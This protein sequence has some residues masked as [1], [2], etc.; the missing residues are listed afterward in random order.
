MQDSQAREVLINEVEEAFTKGPGEH[1]TMTQAVA[2]Q[3]EQVRESTLSTWAFDKA[4]EHGVDPRLLQRAEAENRL[5]KAKAT[6]PASDDPVLEEQFGVLLTFLNTYS[7]ELN[8]EDERDSSD[9]TSKDLLM[10]MKL[11]LESFHPLLSILK[12]ANPALHKTL[13][14][15]PLVSGQSSQ[16][17]SSRL[18][19]KKRREMSAGGGGGGKGRRKSRGNSLTDNSPTDSQQT[20]EFRGMMAAMV[21]K[22]VAEGTVS[23]H[24]VIVAQLLS[25]QK[26]EQHKNKLS[27]PVA[28]VIAAL[29]ESHR[30]E[31]SAA[32][33]AIP[34]LF[35]QF[36]LS[37]HDKAARKPGTYSDLSRKTE[38]YASADA[39]DEVRREQD[40]QDEQDEQE[41]EQEQEQEEQGA[42]MDMDEVLDASIAGSDMTA[43]R[44]MSDGGM[45]STTSPSMITSLIAASRGTESVFSHF[46]TSYTE[47]VDEY[48]VD[49]GED[50]N[51]SLVD[52]FA[53]G[54]EPYPASGGSVFGEGVRS[55]TPIHESLPEVPMLATYGP[56]C[57]S[58]MWHDLMQGVV[59]RDSSAQ[60]SI[61]AIPVSYVIIALL[62]VISASA[63][64][65]LHTQS[66]PLRRNGGSADESVRSVLPLTKVLAIQP[67][68]VTF[69]LIDFILESL[70][71]ELDGAAR[72]QSVADEEELVHAHVY[73]LVW[74]IGAVL[75][76]LRAN[77]AAA[78]SAGMPPSSLGLGIVSIK[79][80]DSL[81]SDTYAGSLFG[82]G[83]GLQNLPFVTR[84]LRKVA[85]CVS[86]E[87]ASIL[88]SH[89]GLVARALKSMPENPHAAEYMHFLRI[90]GIDTFISGISIFLPQQQDRTKLL[91]L[92]LR[93][94]PTAADCNLLYCKSS[95]PYLTP[96]DINKHELSG[97]AVHKSNYYKLVLLQ[98]VCIAVTK[99][100]AAWSPGTTLMANSLRS[101]DKTE[102]NI[103]GSMLAE[104]DADSALLQSPARSP[105]SKSFAPESPGR[106]DAKVSLE[107]MLLQRL[108]TVEIMRDLE[109]CD[110]PSAG[111]FWGELA[112]LRSIQQKH[113]Q[114]F[115]SSMRDAD[116]KVVDWEFDARRCSPNI[117]ITQEAQKITHRSEKL[118]SSVAGMQAAPP[119]SGMYEWAIKV[120]SCERGHAFVGLVTAAA[121]LD[122]YVGCDA[123]GWGLI[124]TKG[125]WHNKV[126]IVSDYGSGFG[127]NST[128]HM[129]YDS[130]AGTLS[131]SVL[132]A[133]FG[134]AFS[135]LPK[136]PL[137]PAISLFQQ[138]DAILIHSVVRA[139]SSPD[140]RSLQ[141]AFIL[142]VQMLCEHTNA[143]IKIAESASCT[144]EQRMLIASHPFIGVLVP[145][146]A[147]GIS[148]CAMNKV[149][150]IYPTLQLLPYLT[151]MTRKL[152][153]LHEQTGLASTNTAAKASASQGAFSAYEA[154]S[155][156]QGSWE[157]HSAPSGALA[158]EYNIEFRYARGAEQGGSEEFPTTAS[159]FTG[160][161]Q[162]PTSPVTIDGAQFGA[163]VAFTE[164]WT[165]GSNFVAEGEV[166]MCGSFFAGKLLEQGKNADK[167]VPITGMRRALKADDGEVSLLLLTSRILYKTTMIC[168][169]AC[170]N[171]ST[172]LVYGLR[173]FKV[174]EYSSITL[175][176]VAPDGALSMD[177]SDPAAEEGDARPAEDPLKLITDANNKWLH[178]DLLSAGLALDRRLLDMIQSE[179]RYHASDSYSE[180]AADDVQDQAH[181]MSARSLSETF[182][183]KTAAFNG[184]LSWWLSQ[185]FPSLS[186]SASS[187]SPPAS[188]TSR[189]GDGGEALSAS[190]P[191]TGNA[192]KAGA[193]FRVDEYATHHTGQSM[194]KKMGGETMQAARRTVLAA[195]AKHSGCVCVCLAE[196]ESLR[197]GLKLDSDRPSAP[198]M[199]LWRAAKK[200]VEQTIKR[201]QDSG[202]SYATVCES[203]VSMAS[204]LLEVQA[205]SSC[206]DVA[207]SL[208]ILV[209]SSSAEKWQSESAIAVQ[210]DYCRLL[211]EAVDF[212]LSPIRDAMWLK[213]QMSNNVLTALTRAAGFRSIHLLFGPQQP[214]LHMLGKFPPISS[215]LL[216]PSVLM[217]LSN[218]MSSIAKCDEA[219]QSRRSVCG[220][221]SDG[222][223]GVDSRAMQEVK[224]SFEKL[225]ESVAQLLSRCT[226]ANNRDGQCIALCTWMYLRVK[227]EDHTFLN[228]I[229]IFRVLQTVLDCARSSA[230][231]IAAE[232]AEEST[233]DSF[234]IQH[235]KSTN[236]R[237][238]Q[239][240]LQVVHSLASQVAYSKEQVG[241]PASR[242]LAPSRSLQRIQSGP[243]TLS[244]SLFDML[245]NELFNGIKSLLLQSRGDAAGDSKMVQEEGDS[246]RGVDPMLL[247]LSPAAK[248]KPASSDDAKDAEKYMFQILRL[249]YIV[250][251][252]KNCLSSLSS[253]K[254]LTLLVAGIGYGAFGVQRRIM[255]LLRRILV[256]M[257]PE[258]ISAFIPS[259][260]SNKEEILFSEAP[261]DDDDVCALNAEQDSAYSSNAIKRIDYDAFAAPYAARLIS[262][263]LEGVSV[264]MPP[265]RST[266][267]RSDSFLFKYLQVTKNTRGFSVE[268]LN[269]LRELQGVPQWRKVVMDVVHSNLS[270]RCNEDGGDDWELISQKL[271][272]A[273]C[274]GVLGGYFDC[275]HLGGMVYVRPFSLI[276]PNST[277]ATRLASTAHSS[278]MLVSQTATHVEIVEMERGTR[279]QKNAAPGTHDEEKIHDKVIQQTACLTSPL[280]VRALKISIS[281]VTPACDVQFFPELVPGHAF[282]DVVEML[283]N[284][285]VP[286]LKGAARSESLLSSCALQADLT[287]PENAEED[288]METEGE[289]TRGTDDSVSPKAAG[290][291]AATGTS[292]VEALNVFA[293]ASAFRAAS[294]LLRSA[295]LSGI[296]VT[297]HAVL[298][299]EILQLAVKDTKC[300]GLSVL[301]FVEMRW[302]ALWDA[303][304]NTLI[305]A[306]SREDA[307]L[308]TTTT[309][310]EAVDVS[311]RS[312]RRGAGAR[313]LVANMESSITRSI[314]LEAATAVGMFSQ[315]GAGPRPSAADR[316]A[317]ASAIAQMV[318]MGLP[319]EWCEVA[320]RRCRNNVEMAINMCFENGDSM[321]QLVAE[322]ALLQSAA[323]T[324]AAA[325][326]AGGS[327][328]GRSRERPSG[329]DARSAGGGRGQLSISASSLALAQQLQEMGFPQS[330]CLRA[331]G[332]TNN[333]V[334]GALSYIL[335]HG[336]ELSINDGR[337]SPLPDGASASPRDSTE[338]YDPLVALA[339]TYECK[340]DL[341]VAGKSGFPSVGCKNFGVSAGKWYYEVT[342][343]TSGCVQIGWADSAYECSADSG[344]GVGDDIHS[345]AYDGWRMYLWHEL[346]IEWGARWSTGDVLGCAVDMDAR[347]MR[348]SLNGFYEEVGMGVGF[349]QFEYSGTLFPCVSFN[350]NE[351]FQFNFGSTPFRHAPPDEHRGYV[352]HINN[353]LDGVRLIR[354]E[355]SGVRY[356]DA[357]NSNKKSTLLNEVFDDSFERKGHEYTWNTRYIAPDEARNQTPRPPAATLPSKIPTG[358][359]EAILTQFAD[360]SKD[361]CVLYS[362][363]AV[364][365]V[366]ESLLGSNANTRGAQQL[367]QFLMTKESLAAM[368]VD[369][370]NMEAKEPAQ[371][372]PIKQLLHL[373]KLCCVNSNRTKL[374][375]TTMA[376]LAP[377]AS[378]PKNLG[379]LLCIGGSPMLGSLT[380]AMGAMLVRSWSGLGSSRLIVKSVLD[381]V[382][383]ETLMSTSRDYALA[384][385]PDSFAPIV[386]NEDVSDSA[387]IGTP[388]LALAVWM[389]SL[390]LQQF[391]S[392]VS[393][394]E[395]GKSS[396]GQDLH[397][398]EIVRYVELLVQSW[399]FV[400][401][402]SNVSV[403]LCAVN[404]LSILLQSVSASMGS[405]AILPLG[406]ARALAS[407]V[408]YERLRKCTMSRLDHERGSYPIFSEYLQALI[409]L[410]SVTCN[411]LAAS[412]DPLASTGDIA[413]FRSQTFDAGEKAT[414]ELSRDSG[415]AGFDWEATSG[416]VMSENNWITMTGSLKQLAT[417]YPLPQARPV[418]DRQEF[419]PELLPGCVVTRKVIMG[420]VQSSPSMSAQTSPVAEGVMD[421]PEPASAPEP[422][423]HVF[424]N[425]GASPTD[426]FRNALREIMQEQTSGRAPSDLFSTP[427]AAARPGA[428]SA[429]SEAGSGAAS[430]EA[431]R[432][433][434]IESEQ[435]GTV[436]GIAA[437]E[438]DVP[439]SAR[440]VKWDNVEETELVRWN[441]SDYK[442]DVTHVTLA[443]PGK[444]S[445]RYGYPPA[446]HASTTASGF[447]A[448]M[449]FG[450]ILRTRK[451][452]RQDDDEDDVVERLVGIIEWPDFGAEVL[453]KGCVWSDGSWT[454]EEKELLRGPKHT[455][456][457]C[458]F[459]TTSWQRGTSYSLSCPNSSGDPTD[460][461][462]LSLVG[463]CSYTVHSKEHEIEV[464]GD[465]R[466]Q[467]T[468]L[469]TFDDKV[470]APSLQLSLDKLSVSR[471]P[472]SG[473]GSC[474]CVFGTVGFSSGVHFWEFK[475]EGADA[476]S[477]YLG[478]GEK[479]STPGLPDTANLRRKVGSGILSNRTA[480]R[481]PTRDAAEKAFVYG[482]NFHTGDLVGVL[483]DMSRGRLSFFLDGLKFGEHNISDLGDAFQDLSPADRV[484]PKTLFPV[485]GLHSNQD[486]VT[487]TQRW[488]SC[489]GTRAVDELDCIDKAWS[490]LNSW[491]LERKNS[492]VPASTHMWIYR[493]GWRNWAQWKEN[494]YCRIRTRCK[495]T[496]VVI[497]RTVRA[498]AEAS[499]RLGLPIAMFRGDR[500]LF[501]R[502]SGR[503]LEQKEEAVV[504]GAFQGR[505]WYRLDTQQTDIASELL[506]SAELAWCL[507]PQDVEDIRFER[508]LPS[509]PSSPTAR[510]PEDPHSV[511]NISSAVR[512]IPLARIPAYHG[513]VL[514]I[515]C[516]Y[517]S[518][519]RD[520]VEIDTADEINNVPFGTTIRAIERRKNSSNITR[521]KVMYEG[522]CGWISERMRGETEDMMVQ[523]LHL[524]PAEEALSQAAFL[525]LA[526]EMDYAGRVVWEDV[527]SLD[528]AMASWEDKVAATGCSVDAP[529][530]ADMSF[531]YY[532]RLATTIDGQRQWS[533]EADMQLSEVISRCATRDGVIPSNLSPASILRALQQIDN[534]SS[535][536]LGLDPERA[537]ARAALM[538]VANQLIG[539]AL[540]ALS[541]SLPEEK[542]GALGLGSDDSIDV[543]PRDLTAALPVSQRDAS[544]MH[545]ES[546]SSSPVS[547]PHRSKKLPR[548]KMQLH[549]DGT[550]VE[551]QHVWAPACGARRL[552]SLRRLFFTHTKLILWDSILDA[553]ETPTNLQHDEY[554]DPREIKTVKLNRV[555]ATQ[556]RLA[557][558]VNPTDRLRQSVFGQLHKEARSWPNSAFRRS[559]IGKGHGGQKRSFKVQFLGEGVNDYGGPYRALFDQIVDELQCDQLLV[560]HK[561]SERCLLP[562]LV[563][564][565]NR[566]S[567]VGANQDKFVLTSAPSS[568][569][570]QELCQFFG[571]LV[572]TAVRH[573][574][575]LAIDFSALLWRTLVKSPV[576]LAHLETVDSLTVK[577]IH[578]VVEAGL[579]AERAAQE[580]GTDISSSAFKKG[581][582][583]GWADLNFTTYLP[584]GGKVEL[585]PGG[586]DQ[587]VTLGNWRAYVSLLEKARLS[588]SQVMFKTF[589]DGL[590]AVLPVKLLPLFTSTELEELVSG[591]SKVDIAL[592]RQCTE[593]DDVD[594]ES[595]LVK[596]FWSV[597]E[598]FNNDERTSFLRFV[599][600]R[601]RLPTS[602][603]DFPMNFKLQGPQ[604]AAKESKD[605]D[606]YLPHA[607]TCFFSLSLPAYSSL[608]VMREKLLYAINNSPNMDA[609][610]RLHSAEG[611]DT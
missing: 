199:E 10:S 369:M 450:I 572:G 559:Y 404:M 480:Y 364:L 68:L 350:R 308:D 91:R 411:C 418:L 462:A 597:L 425:P 370:E 607:Q 86:C 592:L 28:N 312:N 22:G 526:G 220:H 226:W 454:F 56:F 4:R 207:E 417:A 43:D 542:L 410:T 561:P 154:Q 168:T 235:S 359:R 202:L 347:V 407:H 244:K 432:T 452:P 157:L 557:A 378:I 519:M 566:S 338:I 300:G 419:P 558:I 93:T 267:E 70:I 186:G 406:T 31:D 122:S 261:L 361:L 162:G 599:W 473:G 262:I 257:S 109:A 348:F 111:L 171:M 18:T 424:L 484:K 334:D 492:H 479:G 148:T 353:I 114:V 485:V 99:A 113:L 448:E 21:G 273:A 259:L 29:F 88:G 279:F 420:A 529:K 391:A 439:G 103:S 491:S 313:S 317:Q 23:A 575:T 112:L 245:Y 141:S 367:V 160:S 551:A 39:M 354:K 360:V 467:S 57:D 301:E 216:Q 569:L 339:G 284:T 19:K 521:F 409:E 256:S 414:E 497:N 222:L 215:I 263:F 333:D 502:S 556:S 472:R 428:G 138:N 65:A 600:A 59:V 15:Q 286:W 580:A 380:A 296:L 234:V 574:L 481:S 128:V 61:P 373:L 165:L 423:A 372:L 233:P 119:N 195:L 118:W 530:D 387:A 443:S 9:L 477:V 386:A 94:T 463:N 567:G 283:I 403:K 280:P 127:T 174:G 275:F 550:A 274:L 289:G 11:P 466:L 493:D 358:D 180:N 534:A 277:F 460:A 523:Y 54:S 365:R 149:S 343:V 143:L 78:I 34:N 72:Q 500:F 498:C 416:L 588:E 271:S 598:A 330:W 431:A 83:D 591:N 366:V 50:G 1:E 563:P 323:A 589:R 445:R 608:E 152:A 549:S 441:T 544:A 49:S 525:Q 204:F 145:S 471:N 562:L 264:I 251:N 324:R 594:G 288:D 183:T 389:T 96:E 272:H 546:S 239:L 101:T 371:D 570:S 303:Y 120:D 265:T 605:A 214:A 188:P 37:T 501:V 444:I 146:M 156:I 547:S 294:H 106:V 225:Y 163:R 356:H 515:N 341:T 328:L 513:A 327:R 351:S 159:R 578:E 252:S 390:L 236:K 3:V 434:N 205:S 456:W 196:D 100:D 388:N 602:V 189:S 381:Q 185:V 276:E 398:A 516:E 151:I 213:T 77:L 494:A 346:P 565:T 422:A 436:V 248:V 173:S 585:V 320:L 458:R 306:E 133:D 98:K 495:P 268:C 75:T 527:Q 506:E 62:T 250:S 73:F 177:A 229:G 260:F 178:S 511:V 38:A 302:N 394:Y 166:S 81:L 553:T 363:V 400:L 144:N 201:K 396:D 539:Y 362:R 210:T 321:S 583:E 153:Y 237:L 278:G 36:L 169:L 340:P 606:A 483:L 465:I 610:V 397:M 311:S 331:L 293:N 170:G 32:D 2:L 309:L 421:E 58:Q 45:S 14:S 379:T 524:S 496:P 242:E 352:H 249:L 517:G 385:Q 125:L 76:V 555:R 560:G 85:D 401:R 63:D 345:W 198:I 413:T 221:Y 47:T 475:I 464:L 314:L 64:Q 427:P 35:R 13:Q 218:A 231:A 573:N 123:N 115:S 179:I 536:L 124:G 408:D 139:S 322:D 187:A 299:S 512:D 232:K 395:F 206:Q 219:A 449:N 46:G 577:N 470:K 489:I 533:V 377:E 90:A 520:G 438:G 399:A 601:S 476:G 254:W 518:V 150:G 191:V 227:P 435:F 315:L 30:D 147:A 349:D 310:L 440:V 579:A 455:T 437:W 581:V 223:C 504:L 282:V 60:A 5:P 211:S 190:R 457:L 532:V 258:S 71:A 116:V 355:L 74:A 326:T 298:L 89:D 269:V 540:P 285:A 48:T 194:L 197:K 297:D 593:Y 80:S 110:S 41:Q 134:V 44:A 87:D 595:G 132:G 255:R 238:S 16:Q 24:L 184:Y 82:A 25:V 240:A 200:V 137:F 393:V 140:I 469:F 548:E 69:Q 342:L 92:L 291:N 182:Q 167:G 7:S 604:G 212:L 241:A 8:L 507:S 368:E 528:E 564:S 337:E 55:S 305:N 121:Q 596:N 461:Y 158:K 535:P 490:L 587:S 468:H 181:E 175:S 543:I 172:C 522:T 176:E 66:A 318:D 161:G 155:D 336:E 538:R 514:Y 246:P 433:H 482:E 6:R 26:Q 442:F 609:D 130:D 541:V 79:E 51:A 582:P 42:R 95:S 217:Q 576:S 329:G 552:R 430:A 12:V 405:L 488:L 332:A 307:P 287:P 193:G 102:M 126:K 208:H 230:K 316:A 164:S 382:R 412:S 192:F 537:I 584:D 53:L 402:A 33:V 209:E 131:Y 135:S 27:V 290:N 499:I 374:F 105:S 40:E 20:D 447:G 292:D 383:L 554:E 568:P 487:I 545:V 505:L 510:R 67:N 508:K 319:P 84:I 509:A 335:S 295:E 142:Y 603:Q 384:W 586:E 375:H 247:P 52:H 108:G 253:P 531:E 478:V 104:H 281:D 17:K 392:E 429:G 357:A 344:E 453:V 129:R 474:G 376:L 270:Q 446:R 503:E 136:E 243:D 415:E 571:K 117:S 611:W 266:D 224:N 304:S 107:F 459:N 97:S 325:S 590:A 451:L 426:L 486:R 203:L 228:R